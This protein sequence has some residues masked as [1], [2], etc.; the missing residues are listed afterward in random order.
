MTNDEIL[1]VL[2]EAETDEAAAVALFKSTQ[3]VLTGLH[4]QNVDLE[5]RLT[6]ALA[7]GNVSDVV[8]A[9]LV[10]LSAQNAALKAQIDI[11]AGGVTGGV[12]PTATP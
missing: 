3:D 2:R 9:E 10:N 12:T 8:A 5:N 6:A 4:S 11:N 1:K 7:A